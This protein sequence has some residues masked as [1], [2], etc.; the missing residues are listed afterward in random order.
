[1]SRSD[2]RLS[3]LTT[4]LLAL[5]AVVTAV[6]GQPWVAGG[7][8]LCC[9]IVLGLARAKTRAEK[10]TGSDL[11]PLIAILDVGFVTQVPGGRIME[12]NASASRILG[13]T[14]DQLMGR[15]SLD[16]RWRAIHE[17]GSDYPG[18][19]HP[20]MIALRTG[21]PVIGQLMG[22][23][24][25]DGSLVWLSITSTPYLDAHGE[26]ERAVTAF[27]DVTALR[28]AAADLQKKEATQRAILDT[29]LEAIIAIDARGVIRLANP[30]A[31]RLFG[32]P[33]GTL[34]GKPV[35][36]LLPEPHRS[37]HDGYLQRYEQTGERRIIGTHR[38]VE[39]LR[40][41]GSLVPVDLAISEAHLGKERLFVGVLRD[42]S[43][44][45]LAARALH[46]LG[47]FQRSVLDSANV[48][49]ISTGPDGVI[50][51]FNA[52]AERL[53]GWRAEELIGKQTPAV[54]H[55]IEEVVQR[56]QQL[57]SELGRPVEP[58]FESFVGKVRDRGG[59]DENEWTYVRKDGS[60][61][62]VLLSVTALRN[63]A[64]EITGWL[65]VAS[66]LTARK[67]AE[68]ELD[69]FFSL[70]VGLLAVVDFSGRFRRLNPAFEQLLGW[71]AQEMLGHH[72]SEFVH[73][74]DLGNSAVAAASVTSGKDL[75]SF[76][77][78]YRTREGKWR[79]LRWTAA[80][81]TQRQLMLCAAMDVTSMLEA[82]E[83][84]RRAK[85]TAEAASRAKADFL[86]TM[87][88]EIRTPLN[89]VI[90]MAGLLGD[91]PLDDEQR[92]M[93]D[94]VR[95][96]ADGLLAIIND[97]LDFSKIEAGKLDL[98]RVPF[99]P[100]D[101]IDET[102]LML[103]ERAQARGL[104]LTGGL[105][106]PPCRLIG[107]PGRL[108]QILVNLVGNAIKFTEHGAVTVRGE[109]DTLPHDSQHVRL[110][111]RVS[112]TGIGIAPEQQARLFQSFTQAD[113]STTRK[114]GGTGLG[115][116][117]SLRLA[118]AMGGSISVHSS[119]GRGSTFTVS[120]TLERAVADQPTLIRREVLLVM[121]GGPARL[122]LGDMLEAWGLVVRVS[123]DATRIHNSLG[124]STPALVLLDGDAFPD[125]PA[126]TGVPALRWNQRR[127]TRADTQ[128]GW[129]Q[130][131]APLGLKKL[132]QT[133]AEL[134]DPSG[135][136]TTRQDP[137]TDRLRLRGRVLVVEDN[138]V[139]QRLAVAM[140]A[141][142]GVQTDVAGNG[143]EAIEC[144][145]RQPYDL[146]LMDAQMP[147][148]DGYEA[149]ATWRQRES[150]HA[151]RHLPIIAMTANAMS[152]DRERCLAAGMDDYLSKPVNQDEL[153]RVLRAHLGSAIRTPL[154]ESPIAQF[155]S[156]NTSERLVD[157]R[158]ISVL[159]RD[160]GDDAIVTAAI[161]EFI[162]SVP[163]LVDSATR[164]LAQGDS[165]ALRLCSHA[166][167]GSAG[168]VGASAL[169][170]SAAHL[171]NAARSN[172]LAEARIHLGSLV[173]LLQPTITALERT[174]G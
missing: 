2:H 100:L 126:P 13:L 55:V 92:G 45:K 101:V 115:L 26:V 41:D 79:T 133:L 98:E 118:E 28:S 127:M 159:R 17:D 123:D 1:M 83:D 9:V 29:V 66:D 27:S 84:L 58:G 149:T 77:N 131:R 8:G 160:V 170:A 146:V 167:K 80:S 31:D 44:T 51:L 106:A 14:P 59:A 120:C 168:A 162:T 140:L 47:D 139:N 32:H 112:D 53:L 74:D 40:A 135:T 108:R 54:I 62:P 137:S 151:L 121:P 46:D 10:L 105:V 82:Q 114:Y 152:G 43:S 34:I 65:G 111:V 6:L 52:A 63:P 128:D 96:C 94:T 145:T 61:L 166:I 124:L 129:I 7:L 102:L 57:T 97:I 78:R 72:Y 30:G 25:P 158:V 73:P 147:E 23:H 5:A 71:T 3:L 155:A 76:I 143:R 110:L 130:V 75:L 12:F 33:P 99:D 56:A 93:I 39:A 68:G 49:I 70:A 122:L 125:V 161:R 91:T 104:T 153:R 136:H 15:T 163:A 132:R 22:V 20:T 109:L 107:D 50:R 81:D 42:L 88:H 35:T 37:Q 90:G 4:A 21:K 142:L 156:A 116:T 38:E 171:E 18:V 95:T 148:M 36:V 87:S 67:Q 119:P 113:S 85:E 150:A 24:R 172:D 69:R 103:G 16:P 138:P 174:A 164:T 64:G 154:P 165:A 144:L 11:G 173:R 157:T 19:D 86:A 134:W 48:S 89:G 141:K 60:R 169:E 117:I